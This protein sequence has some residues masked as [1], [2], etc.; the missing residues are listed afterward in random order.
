M[1][2]DRIQALL[3]EGMVLAVAE[4][5]RREH[6][7]SAG[8]VPYDQDHSGTQFIIA[9]VWQHNI[10]VGSILADYL[11]LDLADLEAFRGFVNRWGFGGLY[12]LSESLKGET[13]RTYEEHERDQLLLQLFKEVGNK[14][15]DT[16]DLY[17]ELTEVCLGPDPSDWRSDLTPLER[18]YVITQASDYALLREKLELRSIR[19]RIRYMALGE[20]GPESG[21]KDWITDEQKGEPIVHVAHRT[22]GSRVTLLPECS[23]SHLGGVLY[24]E[25]YDMLMSGTVMRKCQRCGH[26]F[27]ASATSKEAF[28]ERPD[29]EQPR[30]TC[31]SL[32]PRERYLDSQNDAYFKAY[33][34]AY[35]ARARVPRTTEYEREE[36]KKWRVGAT[37]LLK[38]ARVANMPIE[39]FKVRLRRGDLDGGLDRAS[40]QE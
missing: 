33:R 2:D 15:H 9:P 4:G 10:Q 5:R 29:P 37:A 8:L 18:Y 19:P 7:R 38:A 1:N 17:E 16:K 25:F 21:M 40:R 39:E 28:C 36:F 31:R 26:L 35:N 23:C 3:R 34:S 20:T 22:K 6:I 13:D 27:P 12:D 32:G 24:A 11:T 14:L 30:A